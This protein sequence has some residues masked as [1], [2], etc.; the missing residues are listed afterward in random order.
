[1]KNI[2]IIITFCL[3]LGAHAN[4]Q[5]KW[6]IEAKGGYNL[7]KND[8]KEAGWGSGATFGAGAIYQWKP[9]IQIGGNIVYNNFPYTG[10]GIQ[11]FVIGWTVEGKDSYSIDNFVLFRLHDKINKAG[12]YFHTR[13]GVSCFHVG[14]KNIIVESTGE[15]I[16]TYENTNIN[17]FKPIG[18]IGLG[19]NIPISKSIIIKLESGYSSTFDAEQ[20]YF[21]MAFIVHWK[22]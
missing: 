20:Q 5:N 15:I 4:A 3:I 6:G 22:L 11:P 19:F 13:L 8:M 2:I 9:G 17:E 18:A 21:P 14:Q 7:I 1:M 16:D 10:G 12:L